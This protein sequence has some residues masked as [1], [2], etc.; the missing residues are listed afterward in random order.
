MRYGAN[1]FMSSS[2]FSTAD[3]I[4]VPILKNQRSPDGRR[5]DVYTVVWREPY[6][7]LFGRGGSGFPDADPRLSTIRITSGLEISDELPHLIP[8]PVARFAS[9]YYRYSY[10]DDNL[11]IYRSTR[12]SNYNF[13]DDSFNLRDYEVGDNSLYGVT[14][15][16]TRFL[17]INDW[18]TVSKGSA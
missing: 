18:L 7:Y 11:W 3:T 12:V 17:S 5:F 10:L 1:P 14:W 13:A 15:L 4:P 16:T 9:A 6:F 8:D 2:V